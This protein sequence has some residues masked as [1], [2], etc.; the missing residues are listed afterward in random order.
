[1]TY[2]QE[3]ECLKSWRGRRLLLCRSTDQIRAII[4]AMSNDVSPA[5]EPCPVPAATERQR[6]D[7]HRMNDLLRHMLMGANDGGGYGP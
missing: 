7:L 5:A 2:D 6:Y 1:M 3:Q 4:N